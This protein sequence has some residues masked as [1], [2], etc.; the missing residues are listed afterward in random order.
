ML[1]QVNHEQARAVRSDQRRGPA[2]E[3]LTQQRLARGRLTKEVEHA[4]E[5]VVAAAWVEIAP[6]HGQQ[7][8][9]QVPLFVAPHPRDLIEL[10]VAG[11]LD[12]RLDSIQN[13][14]YVGVPLRSREPLIRPGREGS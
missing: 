9:L 1:P 13:V 3:E 2:T 7:Q 6:E 11:D 8:Q 10:L 12:E 5:P 4:A 14:T